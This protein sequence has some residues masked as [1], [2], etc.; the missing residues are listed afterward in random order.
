MASHTLCAASAGTP[1]TPPVSIVEAVG[2]AV[3]RTVTALLDWQQR[4]RER[5][6]LSALAPYL[7][8]DAGVDPA[9]AFREA[10]KPFWRS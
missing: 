7:T 6:E 8:K 2:N 5:R 3:A 9:D 4:A 1:R 10:G